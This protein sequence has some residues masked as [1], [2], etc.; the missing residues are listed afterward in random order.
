MVGLEL[1][2]DSVNRFGAAVF[3]TTETKPRWYVMDYADDELHEF[4]PK[5]DLIPYP[6]RSINAVG[7]ESGKIF[8]NTEDA[9]KYVRAVAK[10]DQLM[11]FIAEYFNKDSPAMPDEEKRGLV[12]EHKLRIEQEGLRP[13]LE[14]IS[15]L[16]RFIGFLDMAPEEVIS[17]LARI[18]P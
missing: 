17:G 16:R 2:L 9:V 4:D 8:G 7:Y 12:S 18:E 15:G 10:F 5:R 11:S 13:V 1:R 6:D 3:G 14:G